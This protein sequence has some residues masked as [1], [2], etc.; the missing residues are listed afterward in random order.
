MGRNHTQ[1]TA[2]QVANYVIY[3]ASQEEVGDY[4][5]R[6]GI[7]NLK[8]QKILYFLQAYFLAK[9]ERVLFSEE[10]HAWKHGPVI[11][12]IYGEYKN[13]GSNPIIK[14]IDTSEIETEDKMLIQKLWDQF[15]DYSAH[16]LVEMTH[17]HQPWKKAY[18]GTGQDTIIPK[19]ELAEYYAPLFN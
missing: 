17:A 16:K 11:P 1:Y 4:G 13:Y 14:E 6:E 19:Q 3:L 7:T 2:Q 18:D 10:I 15:G 12:Q 5:E 8:L 9:E